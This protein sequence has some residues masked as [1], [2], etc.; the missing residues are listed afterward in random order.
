MSDRLNNTVSLSRGVFVSEN[1]RDT[2]TDTDTETEATRR[3]TEGGN[4][5]VFSVFNTW[6]LQ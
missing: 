6:L 3:K 1:R 2:D 5:I 4:H